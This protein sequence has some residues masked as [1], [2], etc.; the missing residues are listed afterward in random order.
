VPSKSLQRA[1]V[2]APSG[3]Q[4]PLGD[5][6]EITLTT[7]PAMI[8]DEDGLLAGY[9][10]VD[11]GTRD[12]GGYVARARQ[13]LGE[14]LNLPAGYTLLWTGQYE[15]QVRARERLQVL[16]PVVFLIIFMLLHMIFHSVSEAAIVMLSVLYAMTGGVILQWWLGYN[17]SVAVWVGYIALYGVAVQT[18]VVMVVY[19]HEA[20]DRKLASGREV[21]LE[22]VRD[23]T[24]AASILRLRPKLMTVATTAIG[25]IPVMWSTGV[26]SDV[27]KPIAAPITGGMVTSTIHVLIVTPV[28]FYIM[29]ARALRQGRL[30]VSEMA[31]FIKD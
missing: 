23:A 25:L 26:G 24:I 28:I 8:R 2:K 27:M 30:R 13:A 7:G 31:G 19:L 17:F 9:V 1:L 4:V 3:A 21:T 6:A 15:Y 16:I 12:L 29:K 22:D 11:T 18:G 20:L 14:K 10:Y 5:L